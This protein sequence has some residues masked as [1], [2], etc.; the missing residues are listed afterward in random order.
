MSK[1]II[2]TESTD[3][4]KLKLTIQEALNAGSIV[5]LSGKFSTGKSFVIEKLFSPEQ[6]IATKNEGLDQG[7]IEIKALQKWLARTGDW[8]NIRA[9]PVS[10]TV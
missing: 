4:E 2:N 5:M 1:A 9:Y 3:F 10:E 7:Y 6:V 8:G